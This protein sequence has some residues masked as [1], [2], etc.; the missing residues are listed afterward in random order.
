MLLDRDSLRTIWWAMPKPNSPGPLTDDW[1]VTDDSSVNFH[2]VFFFIFCYNLA[3]NEEKHIMEIYRWVIHNFP[4][5]RKWSRWIWP[6]TQMDAHPQ[7]ILHF[8]AKSGIWLYLNWVNIYVG[9]SPITSMEIG[10]KINSKYPFRKKISKKNIF[11]FP[12][13]PSLYFLLLPIL[14]LCR[15]IGKTSKIS[16]A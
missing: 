16:L 7:Q 6:I 14:F 3:K 11:L 13:P 4:V 10:S 12:S 8:F 2:D 1:K 5:I 15:L 9:G